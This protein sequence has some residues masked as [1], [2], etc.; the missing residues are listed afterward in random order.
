MQVCGNQGL[1]ECGKAKVKHRLV[2]ICYVNVTSSSSSYR[3]LSPCA[4]GELDR[5]TVW[6]VFL[7][8]QFIALSIMQ[9]RIRKNK[10]K[11][12][13]ENM[14]KTSKNMQKIIR[15]R[16]FKTTIII[17]NLTLS[18]KESAID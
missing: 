18:C 8:I 3:S 4:A 11:N 17:S 9:F 2:G 7:K 10:K 1:V 6:C 5:I 13:S 12:N 15:V 16:S 14:Q